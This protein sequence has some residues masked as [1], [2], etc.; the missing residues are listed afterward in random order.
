MSKKRAFVRYTKSGEIVPGSL[1]IT[2]NG[3]YPDKSSLWQEVNVDKCCDNND[4]GGCECIGPITFATPI[5]IDFESEIGLGTNIVINI[6]CNPLPGT[7]QFPESTGISSYISRELSI[8]VDTPLTSAQ[9]LVDLINTA[10]VN[11]GITAVASISE[12]LIYLTV[13][14]TNLLSNYCKNGEGS[15]TVNLGTIALPNPEN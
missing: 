2:T 13:N 3:G 4:G 6:Y 15:F 1:I 12:N 8:P 9:E 10:F 5:P 11:D 14:N 7:F